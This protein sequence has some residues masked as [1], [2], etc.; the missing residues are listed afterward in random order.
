[1][2]LNPLRCFEDAYQI[3]SHYGSLWSH[4]HIRR[5]MREPVQGMG[6]DKERRCG[7]KGRGIHRREASQPNAS[8]LRGTQNRSRL[9]HGLARTTRRASNSYRRRQRQRTQI[10]IRKNQ[11]RT[12]STL[13]FY[14]GNLRRTNSKNQQAGQQPVAIKEEYGK[15]IRNGTWDLAP[16]QK[17][18]KIVSS[19]RVFMQKGDEFECNPD[20]TPI[21]TGTRLYKSTTDDNNLMD[22]PKEYQSIVGSQIMQFYAQRILAYAIANNVYEVSQRNPS[23]RYHLQWELG[24]ALG[25]IL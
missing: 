4:H 12:W 15:V 25:I 9:D 11:G 5:S 7:I 14:C 16:R 19:K 18:R 2:A 24:I 23:R 3:L 21:A 8:G 13:R 10:Q 20:T 17:G 22:D 6:F 1:M